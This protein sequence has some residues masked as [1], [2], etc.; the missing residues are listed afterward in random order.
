MSRGLKEISGRGGGEEERKG[1]MGRTCSGRDMFD[2]QYIPVRKLHNAA[3]VQTR[4]LEAF[5]QKDDQVGLILA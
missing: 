4:V 5:L 1:R 2:I 3:L